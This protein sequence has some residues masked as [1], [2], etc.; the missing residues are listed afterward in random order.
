MVAPANPA[1]AATPSN[2]GTYK[3]Q[4]A[5]VR[6]KAEAQEMAEKVR[7]EAATL[8]GSRTFE[9]V[10]DVYG[11]MGRFYRVRIGSYSEPAQALSACASLR[12]R[13]M[14]CMVIDH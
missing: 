8:V 7:E 11:N 10:E 6:T 9:I 5:A 12:D 2:D 4:L 1:P 14:D 13:R 3:L